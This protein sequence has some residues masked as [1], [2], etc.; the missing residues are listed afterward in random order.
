MTRLRFTAAAQDDLIEITLYI[1]E[2]SGSRRV[3]QA[4]RKQLR[5]KCERLASLPGTMGRD[6]SEL[7]PGLRS[8]AFKGYVIFYRYI[9][10]VMEVVNILEGHRDIEAFYRGEA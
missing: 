1:A 5:V 7:A 3:A 9:D 6:R 4:F 2:L 8:S 10:N